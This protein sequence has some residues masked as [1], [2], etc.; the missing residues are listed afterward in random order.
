MSKITASHE[1]E[2]DINGF[3]IKAYN[4]ADENNTRVLS[5]SDFLRALGRTGKAKGG[6]KYD[7]EFGLPV[8]LTA[9]NL[10]EFISNELIENSSPIYFTDLKGVDSIGYKADLLPAVCYV[11]LDALDKERLHKN[12]M[13]IADQ[14]KLLIRGFATV[15][16]YALIDEATGF[17]KERAKDALQKFFD[18][19]FEK[20]RKKWVKTFPDEFFETIY[21]MKGWDWELAS[22]GQKPGVI[23][24]YINDFVWSRLAPSVLEEL[25]R[26]NPKTEK[27]YR[28]YKNP[29]FINPDFGHP[30]LK[31]HLSA[32]IALG[33]AS[34][35]NWKNFQ[36]LTNR[37]FPQFGKTLEIGYNDNDDE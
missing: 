21:K 35:Y 5:R 13:H 12:Q 32:L 17:Q 3:K 33:K 4:L 26:I 9:N 22:K 19:F 28:K 8:F 14:A 25:N 30:L 27:G 24:T 10:K 16:I 18:K 34:G 7:E 36:R 37:A 29:Q 23:G 1:G 15:G 6:R 20:D 2:I 31:Q 11:F